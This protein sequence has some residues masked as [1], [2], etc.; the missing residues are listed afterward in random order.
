M[1]DDWQAINR[2]AGSDISEFRA[3]HDFNSRIDDKTEAASR[4]ALGSVDVRKL[5][6]TFRCEQQIADVA[7]S[8]VMSPTQANNRHIDK[9]VS[10]NRQAAG[11]TLKI[12]EHVDSAKERLDALHDELA[13]LVK[14]HTAREPLQVFVLTR[15]KR[16][17][18]PDGLSV[19]ALQSL[20]TQ[21]LPL[22][23][24]VHWDSMHATK[25]LGRDHV[26]LV[27][28]DSGKK[29]FPSDHAPMDNLIE[30]LL[31]DQ[32]DPWEE[33]RRLFYVALTRA[34]HGVTLLC[35]AERPSMFVNELLQSEHQ[36]SITYVPLAQIKRVL[37]P[38]C[39]KGWLQRQNKYLSCTRYPYCS[40][41]RFDK[42]A[43]G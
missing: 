6:A 40:N 36:A 11:P 38:V 32:P 4:L 21:Y 25:G 35:A 16:S 20:N 31:P 30:A 1:G 33:E 27:G 18:F 12:V 15:S 19:E 3:L 43:L 29:G 39:K 37:C 9:K 23:L 7:R 26:I 41:K 10:S 28:M 17:G 2:F 22:G 14:R 8:F 42:T 34:K 5:S 24:D 13:S